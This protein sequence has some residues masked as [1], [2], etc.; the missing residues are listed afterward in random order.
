MEG[1]RRGRALEVI[2]LEEIH[3]ANWK[4]ITKSHFLINCFKHPLLLLTGNVGGETR[5]PTS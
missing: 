2:D 3:T 1:E 4:G 5:R